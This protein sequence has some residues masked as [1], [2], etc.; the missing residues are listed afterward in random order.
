MYNANRYYEIWEMSQIL[1]KMYN[2]FVS[3]DNLFMDLHGGFLSTQ[4]C[5]SVFSLKLWLSLLVYCV[6]LPSVLTFYV[7]KMLCGLMDVCS[8]AVC[9]LSL[10]FFGLLTTVL[11]YARVVYNFHHK[12]CS[13]VVFS[14]CHIIL[15]LSCVH[16]DGRYSLV[17]AAT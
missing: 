14:E 7:I 8:S 10:A 12:R 17:T 6:W 2:D 15:P 1:C 3:L 4:E 13:F 5:L 9:I 16:F 11:I